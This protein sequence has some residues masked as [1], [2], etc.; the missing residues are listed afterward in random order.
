MTLAGRGSAPWVRRLFVALFAALAIAGLLNAFGQEASRSQA[1]AGAAQLR[2]TAPAR[3][4]GGLFYQG[5]VEVRARRAIKSPRIALGPGWTEQMQIN[6]IEPAA[7]SESSRDDRLSLSYAG[8]RAGA[9]LTVWLQL[10]VNPTGAG[11]RDQTVALYDGTTR[12]AR[13]K[14]S[15]RVFP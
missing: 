11:H 3:L 6:T 14:R 7:D 2:V 10:E 9:K 15:V 5:R 1:T 8:M 12:L 4:R 13:V